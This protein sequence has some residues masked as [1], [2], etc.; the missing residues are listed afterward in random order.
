[1]SRSYRVGQ[2]IDIHR[3]RAGRPMQL[4]GVEIDCGVGLEGHSD[5]D[6]ALHALMDALLGAVAAGDLGDHFPPTEDRWRDADSRELLLRVLEIVRERGYETVN[7]DVT[8]VGE[9]PRIGEHRVTMQGTVARLLGLPV[10]AVSVKAST[11]EGLGFTGRGE[12]LA[13]VAVVLVSS[14]DE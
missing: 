11:A 1:M 6:V 4:C 5:A 8:I 13:A 10:S 2:G 12:G 7:C 9:R 14:P 3:Y